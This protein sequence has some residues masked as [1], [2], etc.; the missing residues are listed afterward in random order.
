MA[1]SRERLLYDRH[2]DYEQEYD[3]RRRYDT[4]YVTKRTE[5]ACYENRYATQR[6]KPNRSEPERFANNRYRERFDRY[7]RPRRKNGYV[8][9]DIYSD[10]DEAQGRLSLF[11]PIRPEYL[12]LSTTYDTKYSTL[13]RNYPSYEDRTRRYKKDYY[14]FRIDE[15]RRSRE[16]YEPYRTHEAR[17]KPIYD[18]KPDTVYAGRPKP[19]IQLNRTE[20]K[21]PKNVAVCKPLRLSEKNARYWTTD[22]PNGARTKPRKDEPKKNVK[23]SEV[24]GCNRK[25]VVYDPVCGRKLVAVRELEVSLD[26]MIQNGY[27][28]KHNVPILRPEKTKPEIPALEPNGKCLSGGETKT[29]RKSRHLPQVSLYFNYKLTACG[30]GLHC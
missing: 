1:G 25:M 19:V 3:R 17:R 12:N 24:S 13:P 18:R 6:F 23:F 22:P 27:F 21:T 29:S 28:E 10:F 11:R 9:E 7:E 5:P 2:S 20:R 14:D 4:E 15:R 8:F 26:Q 16:L 30:V